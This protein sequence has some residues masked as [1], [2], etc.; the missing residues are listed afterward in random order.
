M[1]NCIDFLIQLRDNNNRDWFTANKEL[2]KETEKEF[3]VFTEKLIEG[4]SQFDSSVKYLHAKDCTFRIY[5]DVRF[6]PN[7]EPYKTH[8]AAYICPKG[9]KSG[10]AGY[11]FHLEAPG[12]DYIG[13]HLLATGIH[14]PEPKVLQSIREEIL[15][16]GDVFEK[17]I[18]K[19]TGFKIDESLKLK[20]IPKGFPLDYEYGE[21][22][23]LKNYSLGKVLSDE[24]VLS[25][26]LLENCIT[27]FKKS[28]DFNQILNRAANFVFDEI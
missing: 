25:E 20:K 2:Y 19:A 4:I 27:E 17:A 5:R 18:K 8:M 15:D 28:L 23:K 12:S 9:K 7:K 11:Y 22:L 24:F 14:M 10:L 21:Y 13:S 26:K 3:N 16:H 6:S 1:K